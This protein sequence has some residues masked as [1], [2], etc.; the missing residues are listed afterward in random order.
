MRHTPQQ[1]PT[2]GHARN[3]LPAADAGAS[4]QWPDDSAFAATVD[5]RGLVLRAPPWP[6]GDSNV[7]L[8]RRRRRRG[9]QGEPAPRFL[10]KQG[11]D[12]VA[13]R[14]YA[15]L[16][17][18]LGLPSAVV[19]WAEIDDF[20]IVA[21]RFDEGAVRPDRLDMDAGVA[22]PDKTRPDQVVLLRNA[23]DYFRHVALS[24]FAEEIDGEEFLLLGDRLHH[25]GTARGGTAAP[26]TAA[27]L[28][29]IDAAA[30][31]DRPIQAGKFA[32]IGAPRDQYPHLYDSDPTIMGSHLLFYAEQLASKR[33]PAHYALYVDTLR[34]LAAFADL[35]DRVAADLRAAPAQRW[36]IDVEALAQR[37][38]EPLPAA[39]HVPQETALLPHLADAFAAWI[40]RQQEVIRAGLAT[41]P[42]TVDDMG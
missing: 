5:L 1:H 25:R 26:A 41:M 24:A 39:W 18:Q 8:A 30:C 2:P 12:A 22:I 23:A 29:R 19:Y 4:W 11:H 38:G 28:F 37:T 34:R 6:R 13:E 40:A 16:A 10:L 17:R 20:P 42:G 31:F 21:I 14:V 27:T 33:K 32:S 35:G 3:R 36:R 9:E 15:L 7:I